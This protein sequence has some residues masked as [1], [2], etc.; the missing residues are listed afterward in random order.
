MARQDVFRKLQ[1]PPN[2]GIRFQETRLSVS[3]QQHLQIVDA[4][5]VHSRYASFTVKPR[6]KKDMEKHHS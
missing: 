1:H 5:D 6:T 2:L 4:T 3:L